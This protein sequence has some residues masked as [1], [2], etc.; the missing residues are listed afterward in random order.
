MSSG[1]TAKPPATFEERNPFDISKRSEKEVAAEIAQRLAAWKQARGRSYATQS[2]TVPSTESK[3]IGAPVQPARLPKFGE[4]A[5]AHPA[6]EPQSHAIPANARSAT[7]STTVGPGNAPAHVAPAKPAPAKPAERPLPQAV[8]AAVQRAMP[9]APSPKR[10]AAA[11]EPAI[12]TPAFDMPPALPRIEETATIEPLSAPPSQ[13]DMAEPVASRETDAPIAETREI[14]IASA[15]SASSVNEMAATP[16]IEAEQFERREHDERRDASQARANEAELPASM[17]ADPAKAADPAEADPQID[18]IAVAPFESDVDS[19]RQIESPDLDVPETTISEIDLATAARTTD[20]D[21]PWTEPPAEVLSEADEPVP[22]P[23]E[24]EPAFGAP[25]A[26]EAADI[27]RQTTDPQDV[28]APAMREA[29]FMP[30][31]PVEPRRI[32]F[33]AIRM[34]DTDAPMLRRPVIVAPSAPAVEADDIEAHRIATGEIGT[35]KIAAAEIAAG[36]SAASIEKPRLES[37]QSEIS[38]S[39]APRIIVRRPIFPH[40]EPAEWEIRPSSASTR[41]QR[42]RGG[43]GWAIG[44][45]A[46]LLIAGVTA[47]AA[48]WQQGRTVAPP[49]LDQVVALNPLP[50]PAPQATPQNAQPAVGAEPATSQPAAQQPDTAQSAAVQPAAPQ[51]ETSQPG[52][53]QPAA[54]TDQAQNQPAPTDQAQSEPAPQP[55]PMANAETADV[56]QPAPQEQASLSTVANGG[57]VADAPI[58]VPP[59]PQAIQPELAPPAASD[60]PAAPSATGDTQLLPPTPRPFQSEFAATPFHPTTMDGMAQVTGKPTVTGRLKPTQSAS[61]AVPNAAPSTPQ[62]FVAKPAKPVTRKKQV[63]VDPALDQMFNNLIQSLSGGQP[64]NPANKPA[65]PSQRR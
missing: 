14:E 62:R 47:P 54:P 45:G 8:F 1:E 44:L 37:P 55:Q 53:P 18:P 30:P 32:D 39:A 5:R 60:A 21:A 57:E 56:P 22:A 41:S 50:M 2:S 4:H 59:P 24:R 9:P 51:P 36:D 27:D 64:V 35:S 40:I 19:G 6:H 11:P 65:S 49:D 48:I 23:P 38:A 16:D 42:S 25:L 52:V 58:S 63:F 17:A 43:T 33:P 61:I 20:L 31:A 3:P 26:A 29:A 10:P 28:D 7:P 13:I 46:L 15:A 34:L 12:P